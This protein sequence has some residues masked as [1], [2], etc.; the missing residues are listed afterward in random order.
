MSPD[1]SHLEKFPDTS[2]LEKSPD[3]SHLK[4]SPDTNHLKGLGHDIEF[5]YFDTNESSCL[6]LG[7]MYFFRGL[8]PI[9]PNGLF[10]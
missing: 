6:S 8:I 4:K 2:N 7:T 9:V 1:T 10:P 3:T 5:L